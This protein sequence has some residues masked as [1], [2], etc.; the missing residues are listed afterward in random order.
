MLVYGL[1]DYSLRLPGLARWFVSL[2]K[3]GETWAYKDE[4]FRVSIGQAYRCGACR[5]C[6]RLVFSLCRGWIP[7]V[8]CPLVVPAAAVSVHGYCGFYVLGLC[9]LIRFLVSKIGFLLRFRCR[10][11]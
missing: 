11:P 5:G 3:V 9:G 1:V 8:S 4:A 6:A 10:P 2:L 7:G